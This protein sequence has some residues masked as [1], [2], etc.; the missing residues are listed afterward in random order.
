MA[1][2]SSAWWSPL[3]KFA[4]RLKHDADAS[5][6]AELAISL[7]LLVVF[8]VGIFDFSAAYNLRQKLETAAAESA[9]AGAAQ[10]PVDLD[11]PT[12]PGPTSVRLVADVALNYLIYEGVLPNATQGGCI[13][14]NPGQAGLVWTYVLTGCPD[15]LTIT[16]DRGHIM[17]PGGTQPRVVGT[18]V[19]L[20]YPHQW[21]FNKVIGLITA[22]VGALPA[23]ISA[24]ANAENLF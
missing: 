15:T 18:Q 19:T 23:T 20:S 12:P 11:Q 14:T 17:S 24:S 9:I 22:Q 4:S 1:H 5:Q 6:L 2:F 16:V 3:R 10:P 13:L 8:V 7:P 21:Q